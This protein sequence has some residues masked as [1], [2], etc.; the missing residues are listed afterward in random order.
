MCVNA[1]PLSVVLGHADTTGGEEFNVSKVK[2]HPDFDLRTFS[3]NLAVVEL[4]RE[5]IVREAAVPVCLAGGA[6]EQGVYTEAGWGTF[7]AGDS[8]MFN[9]DVDL[10]DEKECQLLLDETNIDFVNFSLGPSLV[11]TKDLVKPE[12]CVGDLGGPLVKRNFETDQ[13]EIV[14]V[15]TIPLMCGPYGGKFPQIYTNLTRFMGWIQDMV[16][17]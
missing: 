13:F 7:E 3:S 4:G 12:T 15:R 8:T 2:I 9:R 11:C 5:V 16:E 10:I 1:G 6:G 14:G 17:Q